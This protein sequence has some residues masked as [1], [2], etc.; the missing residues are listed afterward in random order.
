MR[1]REEATGTATALARP[2][3]E[4]AARMP[5]RAFHAC[6][7][8]RHRQH[9]GPGPPQAGWGA[10]AARQ[11]KTRVPITRSGRSRDV[12]AHACKWI[13][14]RGARDGAQAADGA[15]GSALAADGG[16]SAGHHLQ[17][18]GVRPG[19]GR[20]PR[21]LPGQ[22]HQRLQRQRH[23]HGDDLR[24][25]GRHHPGR[26]HPGRL[27]RGR[28]RGVGHDPRGL[29]QSD[30]QREQRGHH[31]LRVQP[32][33]FHRRQRAGHH[34]AGCRH[35]LCR[36]PAGRGHADQQPDRRR[37]VL[38]RRHQQDQQPRHPDHHAGGGQ[39]PRTVQD[40]Y[41]GPGDRGR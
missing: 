25:A 21:A 28:R 6:R 10:T 35:R 39:R 14:R 15:A 41:A 26:P 2:A 17:R 8:G 11:G 16:G 9:A 29:H 19:A 3:V 37:S 23:R 38:W 31:A 30:A 1:N 20:H 18:H 7:N 32:V 4:N 5:A 40:R 22:R 27:Q 13:R 12:V 33:G 24:P 34:H 36:G